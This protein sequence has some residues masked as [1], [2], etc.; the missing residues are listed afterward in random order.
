[1]GPWI[2]RKPS[3]SF[4]R[5]G[6]KKKLRGVASASDRRS[7]CYHSGPSTRSCAPPKPGPLLATSRNLSEKSLAGKAG[8]ARG[9]GAAG[10]WPCAALR[11]IPPN[12]SG[13][14]NATGASPRWTLP[15]LDTL[16][17]KLPPKSLPS[18]LHDM[19]RPRPLPCP[20][21]SL[22]PHAARAPFLGNARP[23]TRTFRGDL[24]PGPR[25]FT[26]SPSA[27]VIPPNTNPSGLCR[28]GCSLPLAS[29]HPA[30]STLRP[31]G[32]TAEAAS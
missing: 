30:S 32:G 19:R 29:R 12:V 17:C 7:N 1:M 31:H 16:N 2:K 20:R 4:P 10:R 21:F 6:K 24:A 15:Y 11:R 25:H 23:R 27:A 26:P 14:T 13:A 5:L 28:G 9:G 22:S 3:T 18:P 8:I